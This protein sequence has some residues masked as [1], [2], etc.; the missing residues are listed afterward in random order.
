MTSKFKQVA[1]GV[2]PKHLSLFT[3]IGGIDIAAEW[4]GFETIGQCEYADYPYQ[5]LMKHWP[6]VPK[7]RDVKDVTKESF[8]EKC[9]ERELA[10]LSGGFPCQPFSVAG[11]RKGTEDDRHLWPEM[12]RVVRELRP[13]WVLGENVAGIVN[14]ELGSVLS[15]LEG[16]GYSVRAFLVP[17]CG[18]GAWH[19]RERVFVVANTNDSGNRFSGFRDDCDGSEESKERGRITQPESCAG[20]AV[21][22]DPDDTGGARGRENNRM[23]S[24]CKNTHE[25]YRGMRKAGDQWNAEPAVDRVANGIPRRVD[26]LRCLG[27][28]VVPQQAYPILAAMADQWGSL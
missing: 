5:V 24:K 28:A 9:G 7:W 21:M 15:D 14:M 3:G 6:D 27:N 11:K 13:A 16:E 25:T 19:R 8:Y 10:L 18:V 4:A 20:G 12:L 1:D 17:A 22:A 23:G 2:A 26:R